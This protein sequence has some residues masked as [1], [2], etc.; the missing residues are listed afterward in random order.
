MM[1]STKLSGLLVLS[2]YAWYASFSSCV[3]S[4]LNILSEWSL[5]T[6]ISLIILLFVWNVECL[7]FWFSWYSNSWT[8]KGM[9]FAEGGY[10]FVFKLDMSPATPWVNKPDR[11]STTCFKAFLSNVISNLSFT[12]KNVLYSD[13]TGIIFREIW[14]RDDNLFWDLRFEQDL[15]FIVFIGWTGWTLIFSIFWCSFDEDA[16]KF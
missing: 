15:L 8:F 3:T 13:E 16:D 12:F 5:L 1:N 4:C 10:G 9:I 2:Q 11:Y 6:S 7:L 14:V